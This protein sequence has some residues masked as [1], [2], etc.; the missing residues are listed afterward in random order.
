MYNFHLV[1]VRLSVQNIY[2]VSHDRKKF[3]IKFNN[4]KKFSQVKDTQ[5]KRIGRTR[6]KSILKIQNHSSSRQ[7]S[8][9]GQTKRIKF[10]NTNGWYTL[11]ILKLYFVSEQNKKVERVTCVLKKIRLKPDEDL[12]K[13]IISTRS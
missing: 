6:I 7:Q 8:S 3:Q 1:L 11:D 4:S 9:S 10:T 12:M 13:K 2:Q 5:V